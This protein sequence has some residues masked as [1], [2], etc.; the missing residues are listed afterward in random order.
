MA[1]AESLRPRHITPPL[2]IKTSACGWTI[3]NCSTDAQARA[4]LAM[5]GITDPE[6]MTEQQR[7]S[8]VAAGFCPKCLDCAFDDFHQ[9]NPARMGKKAK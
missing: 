3:E 8:A 1:T 7:W 6:H 5:L 2:H 4:E 9:M